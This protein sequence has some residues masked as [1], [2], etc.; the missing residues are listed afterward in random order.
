MNF[1]VPEHVNAWIDGAKAVHSGTLLPIVNPA[2]AQVVSQLVESDA[3]VVDAAVR[4]AA[5]AFARGSWRKT[6]VE[7]RAAVLRKVADLIDNHAAA[8]VESESQVADL[9]HARADRCRSPAR[10]VE[11]PA[12]F[13]L[14]ENRSGDCVRQ[15]LCR[16]TVRG[17][18]TG[19][20][21][22]DGAAA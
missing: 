8:V 12:G 17:H 14:D 19:G 15:Q 9:R 22:A 13:D 1:E 10:S 6:P 2:T 4:A 5:T 7:S 3:T 11:R 21:T 18:A 16:Q 20:C